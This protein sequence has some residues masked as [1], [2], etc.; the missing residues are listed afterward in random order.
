MDNHM[1]NLLPPERRRGLTRDFTLRIA[2]VLVVLV[3]SLTLVAGAMLLPTYIFLQAS[4]QSKKDH[5]ANV[6]H[7]LSASDGAS[8]AARLAT[9]STNAA[10]LTALGSAPSVGVVLQKVL[11]IAH[12][13]IV[14]TNFS[15]TPSAGPSLLSTV[16]VS[17]SSTTRETLHSYQ[18][19]LE[20]APFVRTAVL[21]VSAYANDTNITFT[22]TL[23]LA[24]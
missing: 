19:A 24:P 18:L 5:L 14:L 16:V 2:V 1:T 10:K 11:A 12:P 20:S 8:L 7:A 6:E 23:T 3:T 22:I 4:A 9:L 13:G 15:Y 21:P 17:G